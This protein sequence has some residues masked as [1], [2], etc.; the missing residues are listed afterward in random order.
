[1]SERRAKA[2]R[3]A[4][5]GD[6][7][8]RQPRTYGREDHRFQLNKFGSDGK[9]VIINRPTLHCTGLRG[10]YQRAKKAA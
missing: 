6:Q 5:Y 9:P 10:E 7:S 2:L 4:V 3:R 1:M 8:L